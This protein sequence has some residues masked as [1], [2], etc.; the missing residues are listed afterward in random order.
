MSGV[1]LDQIH[2]QLGQTTSK[3]EAGI[4]KELDNYDPESATSETD[5]LNIQMKLQKWTMAVQ[6]Q[7]NI[8]KTISESM[9]STIQNIR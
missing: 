5:L 9:K 3:A 7:S 6:L 2:K 4:R 8:L 1:N